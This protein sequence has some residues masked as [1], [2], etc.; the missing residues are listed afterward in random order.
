MNVFTVKATQK[1]ELLLGD[2]R[3]NISGHVVFDCLGDVCTKEKEVII[4][5]RPE[6]IRIEKKC[7][8]CEGFDA[9]ADLVEILGSEALVHFSIDQSAVIAKTVYRSD[10]SPKDE[11]TYCFDID[12]I[13]FFDKETGNRIYAK[14]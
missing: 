11:I 14:K 7:D 8:S 13:Y 9:I 4:G 6:N 3:L 2:N 12:Q 1:G 5:V 10:L